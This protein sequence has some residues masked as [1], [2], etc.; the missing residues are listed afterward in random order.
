MAL[1]ELKELNIQLQEL[2]DKGFIR[3]NRSLWA[4]TGAFCLEERWIYASIHRLS[5]IEQANHK[6]QI[7]ISEYQ[8]LV[9]PTT[10]VVNVLEN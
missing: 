4:G 2:L 3:P 10:R 7:S 9:R 5:G 8:G 6:E 1:A